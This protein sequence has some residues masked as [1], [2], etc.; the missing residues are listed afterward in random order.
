MGRINPNEMDNY[1][2]EEM[3]SEWLS[4]KDDGDIERVQFLYETYNDLDA[5]AV[6]KVRING[7]QYDRMVN[8]IRDYEDPVDRCPLCAA[9]YKVE[10]ALILA[11]YSHNDQKIKIW[12]RG[13]TFR[14]LIES[15]FN[16]YPDL[17]NMV[18]EIERHGKKG[19]QK[20]T[21]ELIAMPDVEPVDVSEIK[22]PEFIGSVII[23]ADANA[24]EEFLQTGEFPKKG[25]ANEPQRREAEPSRRRVEEQPV[26]RRRMG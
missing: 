20:T 8:C 26:S 6:H 11:M 13:K 3:E 23:D 12:Q 18:F 14:K 1:S 16:R 4:L 9:G 10:P 2:R 15:K 25:N 7:Q 22:K 21:Y 24:M 19:D 17:S 5:F